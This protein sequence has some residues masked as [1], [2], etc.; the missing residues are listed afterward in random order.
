MSIIK[1]ND[2]IAA[3]KQMNKP[4]TFVAAQKQCII[5]KYIFISCDINKIGH[6]GNKKYARVR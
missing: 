2:Q 1:R 3:N 6:K 4:K 5:I